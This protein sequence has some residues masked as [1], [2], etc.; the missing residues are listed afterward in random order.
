HH[1]VGY[2]PSPRP[3]QILNGAV[4]PPEEA[5]I[6]ELLNG[7]RMVIMPSPAD[8][9][10]ATDGIVMVSVQTPHDPRYGGETP[11]VEQ[12][13]DFEYGYLIQ[14]VRDVAQAA[15]QQGKR[16]T[17]VVIST[18]LPGTT[19]AYLA[20][21]CGPNVRLVYGP[22][23]IAMSTTVQ[24]FLHPEFVLLGSDDP[25]AIADIADLYRTVHDRPIHP[26][27]IESAELTKVAYNCF[28][29]MKIVFANM[30]MEICQKTGADCD[31]VADGL[32]LATDRITSPAYMRGGMG[33]SG[34]C[35]PRDNQA[36]SWLAQRLDLS[37]DLMGYASEAREQQSAWLADLVEHWHRMSDLPVILLGKA[38]KPN[39]SLT[40]GSAGL[41]LAEQLRSRG[42]DVEHHDPF[43]DGNV[44]DESLARA[45]YVVT[46]KHD[47]FLQYGIPAGSVVIDPHGYMPDQPG[48]TTIRI[49]RKS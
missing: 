21:L 9:V 46:T 48:V 23:F 41:L 42:F 25:E 24:D 32:A 43:V 6:E 13:V 49:G 26:V 36:M 34:A 16:I 4:P 28:I 29:S 1:I 27:S 19:R 38:Y 5:G 2:D 18:M 3:Q 37:V 47:C 10:A 17:L 33:D 7:S 11:I 22:Y 20:P 45:V 35:H 40:Q 31:Q 15:E 8:V 30:V 39:V 12:P 44:T 14:A